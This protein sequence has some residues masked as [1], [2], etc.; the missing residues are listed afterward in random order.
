MNIIFH[1]Y[2]SICEPDILEAFRFCGFNVIEDTTEIQAKSIA[3]KDR[4]RRLSE[5]ILTNQTAFVFSVNFFPYISEICERLHILY[6]SL[7]VDCPVLELFS[8]SIRNKCNRIFLFDYMQFQKFYPE[9]PDSIFYLP[10]A[11][12]TNRW[13][14]TLSHLSEKDRQ[15]FSCDIS[16][17]GSL[18]KEKSPLSRLTLD[19]YHM[20]LIS[21]MMEAQLKMPGYFFLEE[22][23]PDSLISTIRR[24]DPDFYQLTDSFSDTSAYTAANYYLGMQI[25]YL[26]RIRTLKELGGYFTVNLYTRSDTSELKEV[27]GICC[28]GGVSTHMEMPKVFYYSKINLN[29]TMRPIQSGLSQRIWDVLGCGG[30]LLSN[31]QSEIPE[32]FTIGKELDCYES[33]GELKEKI[34]YYLSHEDIRREIAH[35]GFQKVKTQ[36]TYVHRI[37]QMMQTLFPEIK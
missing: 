8:V 13:E 36:H 22:A 28:K 35:N 1:R 12:N 5:L 34:S 29:I 10:L 20:G 30:F 37:C 9:N 15:C 24:V 11:V 3:P 26:E 14:Q 32:Y 21:G 19:S 33:L 7:S 23:I 2:G 17:V 18:Y 16:F 27:Q 25:S 6:V 31:Y 4:I